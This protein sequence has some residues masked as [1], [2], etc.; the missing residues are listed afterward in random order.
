MLSTNTATVH[1]KPA[2]TIEKNLIIIQ[3]MIRIQLQT[4]QLMMIF[5]NFKD[6]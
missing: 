3:K 5:D 4:L 1:E 6:K 2:D